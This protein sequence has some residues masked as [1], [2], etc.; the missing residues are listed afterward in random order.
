MKFFNIVVSLT[1]GLRIHRAGN[2]GMNEYWTC[3]TYPQPLSDYYWGS[4]IVWIVDTDMN[5]G[6]TI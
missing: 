5:P 2:R 1:L 3:M 4:T 6:A